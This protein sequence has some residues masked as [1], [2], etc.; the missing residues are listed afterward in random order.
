[1]TAW[2]SHE[3]FTHD[4]WDEVWAGSDPNYDPSE[5]QLRDAL[6]LIR[7]FW[8]RPR[9]SFLEA[10]CG[11]A[12]IAL[13]LAPLGVDVAGVDLS[14]SAVRMAQDAFRE[15]GL[16]GEFIIGDVRA[17]PFADESFDFVY[18]GGVIEHFR[19]SDRAVA[20][21][22]RVLR[23]GGRLL[24]TVPALTLSYPYLFLRGNVPALPLIENVL[25]F[26]QFRLLRGGLAKFGYERS[27]RRRMIR[28][29]LTDGG[30]EGVEVRRFDTYLPLR[31]L[32]RRLRGFARRL[33]R[34]SLFA[35]MYY[36]TGV[37]GASQ[38]ER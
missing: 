17:L 32:P 36:G 10:G 5:P 33:G 30:L 22:A 1:L 12:A 13:N 15:R 2:V 18:A 37:R 34:T 29:L 4:R 6:G 7:R 35:A 16:H 19:E 3:A 23:P 11:P 27:C 20:E 21:M 38:G 24:L 8:P 28:R 31:Q 26:I 25:A 14:P 9:G